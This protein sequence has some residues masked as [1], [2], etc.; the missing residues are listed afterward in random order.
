MRSLARP[1]LRDDIVKELA[2]LIASGELTDRLKEE[3]IAEQLGVSRTP[4]REALLILERDGI[5]I[6]EVNKGFRVSPVNE[7]RVRELYPVLGAL[8]GLAIRDGFA[9]L[10]E[11]VPELRAINDQLAAARTNP[12]RYELDRKFHATL[13][14]GAANTMLAAT[15]GTLKLQ[16]QQ[17]D[18]AHDR[19]MANLEG[20]VKEHAAIVNLIAHDHAD[21]A[22]A[23]VEAHWRGGIDVVVRWLQRAI[24]L[25]VMLG[26]AHASTL[27]KTACPVKTVGNVECYTLT[28]PE[29]RAK[30][31]SRT[32]GIPIVV[33]KARAAKPAEPIVL[34]TGGPGGSE[35]RDG[36]DP[37][38][39]PPAATHDFILFQQRGTKLASP[40]LSCPEWDPAK[41][42]AQKRDAAAACGKR[43]TASGIDLDGYDTAAIVDDFLDLAR[44]LK[45]GPVN[46]YAV[47]YGTE[48]VL[49]LIRKQPKTIHAA[50]LDSVLPTDIRYDEMSVE[51]VLHA[52]DQI[53][54]HCSLD[55]DCRA[56]YPDL[57]HRFEAARTKSGRARD[58]MEA[59]GDVLEEH[60]GAK[61]VPKLVDEIAHGDLST[62]DKILKDNAGPSNLMRGLRLSVWCREDEPDT[63]PAWKY[64]ELQNWDTRSFDPSV[65][66]AWPV[67]PTHP[68]HSAVKSDVPVLIYAGEYDPVTTPTWG[69]RLLRSL[70]HAFFVEVPGQTHVA[71]NGPC[72][73]EIT[74]AFFR[75]PSRLPDLSCIARDP[76]LLFD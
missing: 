55:P 12:K 14:S 18:G 6:S 74:T 38:K 28:V 76:G 4:L 47:S 43:L 11:K 40:E 26:V 45:T 65:C 75:D 34:F 51:G 36:L 54:D 21:Q 5:V 33:M 69:R 29:N 10:K 22:A 72:T 32:I 56:K 46:A 9:A 52:L 25:V 73:A 68:D 71:G 61:T 23:K 57:R 27:K 35:L 16:A 49:E 7:R 15:L 13:C 60:G 64:P 3:A 63:K 70:T 37:A 66:K 2:R 17:V 8:E 30:P 62:V 1:R 41:T 19:G 24:V 44:L 67:T 48:V 20:S 31:N 53:L 59:L 50:V 39:V 42:V 58:I